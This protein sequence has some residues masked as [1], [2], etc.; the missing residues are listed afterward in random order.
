MEPISG[1]PVN[2]G[3]ID[4]W[5][6]Q[7]VAEAFVL[8]STLTPD[9]IVALLQLLDALVINDNVFY[10]PEWANTWQR[11]PAA[12]WFEPMLSKATIPDKALSSITGFSEKISDPFIGQVSGPSTRSDNYGY[13]RGMSNSEIRTSAYFYLSLSD[14]MG[15]YYWAAPRRSGALL[16]DSTIR[17]GGF[18][19]LLHKYIDA[20]LIESIGNALHPFGAS[21]PPVVPGGFGAKLLARCDTRDDIFGVGKEYR[22]SKEATAFRAWLADVDGA[23]QRGGWNTFLKQVGGVRD[24]VD[25]FF[26]KYESTTTDDTSFTFGLSPAVTVTKSAL[27]RWKKALR[28]FPTKR[29]HL[30]FL[31]HHLDSWV[32]NSDLERHIKRLFFR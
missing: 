29:L 14:A 1:M 18:A 15:A 31:R 2:S 8:R 17:H 6:L 11:W 26:A 4:N 13:S 7:L 32:G 25:E 21:M 3:I 24:I 28:I 30:T 12:A 10:V 23:L 5:T 20:K 16:R 19:V 9:H 27:K 22:E